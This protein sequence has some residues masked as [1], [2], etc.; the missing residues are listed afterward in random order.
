MVRERVLRTVAD[1]NTGA[2]GGCQV[3]TRNNVSGG[4]S[5][6]NTS[7]VDLETILKSLRAGDFTAL[8]RLDELGIGYSTASKT[9]TNTNGQTFERTIITFEY[10]GETYTVNFTKQVTESSTPE[11]PSTTLAADNQQETGSTDAQ[12]TTTDSTGESN[13]TGSADAQTTTTDSTGESN[14]TGS[15]DAQTTTTDSTGESDETGGTDAQTTPTTDSTGE[16]DETGSTDAQTSN[17]GLAE[18]TNDSAVTDYDYSAAV[19][20]VLESVA[21]ALIGSIAQLQ[22]NGNHFALQFAR[23]SYFDT[24]TISALLKDLNT[25]SKEFVEN[26]KQSGNPDQFYRNFMQFINRYMFNG[27]EDVVNT[28]LKNINQDN[29]YTLLFELDSYKETCINAVA[30]VIELGDNLKLGDKTIT[31]ENYKEVINSYTDGYQLKEDLKTMLRGIDTAPRI[32]KYVEL[33][34]ENKKA[35]TTKNVKLLGECAS[36][37]GTTIKNK[38]LADIVGKNVDSKGRPQANMDTTFGLNSEGKIEFKANGT[39]AVFNEI[40]EKAK[41]EIKGDDTLYDAIKELGGDEV[42]EKLV[43]AAWINTYNTYDSSNGNRTTEFVTKVLENLDKMLEKLKT[44]PEYLNLYT[45][46]ASYTDTSLTDDLIYYNTKNTAGNDERIK[47]SEPI[48]ADDGSVHIKD[49]TDDKDYQQTMNALLN[50]VINKYSSYL[51]KDK[52]TQLFRKAQKSALE[53]CKTN[54]NDCPYGTSCDKKRVE[55]SSKSW[56]IKGSRAGD[57]ANI[58]MDELVQLTLYYFDKL[59]Y[60]ELAA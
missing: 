24:E 2:M 9:Y 11:E 31:S 18:G 21:T 48:I 19:K 60:Q 8:E 44:N 32:D 38:Y 50:R 25:A 42:I 39:T 54:K 53:T 7:T 45:M 6:T 33:A 22:A 57:G 34:E 51:D 28:A 15:T 13:E 23:Y 58:D 35:I 3:N 40:V 10:E 55:D 26:Y 43:Q 36:G 56:D 4:D 1:P 17:V 52:I 30:S 37:L 27:S 5:T 49:E 46:R 59:L 41:A 29:P 16:S 14:E 12:T 47:S 20:R